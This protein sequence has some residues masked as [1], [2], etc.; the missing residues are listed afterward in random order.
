MMTTTSNLYMPTSTE[1]ESLCEWLL[2]V[3]AFT[4]ETFFATGSTGAECLLMDLSSNPA[5]VVSASAQID[6]IDSRAPD[7]QAL[8]DQPAEGT[9]CVLLNPETDGIEQIAMALADRRDQNAIHGSAVAIFGLDSIG[10][11]AVQLQAI[12]QFLTAGGDLPLYGCNVA[13]RKAGYTFSQGPSDRFSGVG[14]RDGLGTPGYQWQA[15][16]AT[17]ST[18]VPIQAEVGK[19]IQVVAS[20]TADGRVGQASRP[21][22]T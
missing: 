4:T 9:L 22:K 17:G 11:Y 10:G 15:D 20:Y 19:A 18:F 16:G 14:D 8:V 12:G 3:Q 21:T 2:G 6:F 1:G 5:P 13:E 7:C